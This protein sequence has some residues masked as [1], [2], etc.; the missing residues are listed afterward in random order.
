[1]AQGSLTVGLGYDNANRR[2][3]LSYP[4]GTSTSYTYDVAS[5]LTTINHIGPSGIIEALTY[6]YDPAGNRTSLTRSNAAAS[7]LPNAVA[8]ASYDAANEQIAFAGTP[9]T[10]DNNGNLTS[11]GV[12]TYVWDARNR[13][14]KI[15]GGVAGQF[16]YDIR[17]RRTNKVINSVGSQFLYDGNDIAAEVGGGA[18][19]ASYLRSLNVDESFIRQANSGNEHYHADALG[20]SLALSNASGS[21]AAMYAYEPFGRTTITGTSVSSYQYTGRENDGTGLYYYR[22]RY[23]STVLQRF[24]SQDPIGMAGG[25]NFY[26]Y[27]RN[28]PINLTDPLGLKP[29]SCGCPPS[30]FKTTFANNLLTTNDFFFGFPWN[31]TRTG[32]GLLVGSSTTISNTVGTVTLGQALKSVVLQGQGVA[33]LTIPNTL[34][35]GAVNSALGALAVGVS[36]EAGIITGSAIDAGVKSLRDLAFGCD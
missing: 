27:V 28:N 23:Y 7:L 35:S 16:N 33:N 5:R 21:P 20:S 26:S 6:Q 31:F 14:V 15:T 3:S 1:V 24:I 17:G 9:L 13:L 10:Y 30:D 36:L 22:A 11:D 19:G 29:A 18:V 8:S 25:T 4:N 12:N 32:L 34:V 2:T